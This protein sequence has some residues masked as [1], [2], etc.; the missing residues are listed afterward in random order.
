ME[1][2]N[3]KEVREG[4]RDMFLGVFWGEESID[5]RIRAI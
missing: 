3:G 4:V 1:L 2:D 5:V